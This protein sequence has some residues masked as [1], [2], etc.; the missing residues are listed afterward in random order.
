MPRLFL[1]RHA[2]AAGS[3]PRGDA[4]RPLTAYGTA[5]AAALGEW[6]RAQ[7]VQPA[8]ALVSDAR[9]TRQTFEGLGL[10]LAPQLRADLYLAGAEHLLAALRAAPPGP[11]LLVGH[12]PGIAALAHALLA[13]APAAEAFH[14][15]PPGATLVADVP[16]ADC[17]A[18]APGAARSFTF[19]TPEMQRR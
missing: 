11:V 6:L 12:N 18:L 7:P 9:R 3:A 5:Q 1:M 8:T 13:Q 16:G 4:D 17:S 10:A 15:Y 2:Q 19:T 14:S